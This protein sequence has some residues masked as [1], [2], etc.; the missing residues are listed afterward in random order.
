VEKETNGQTGPSGN[1]EGTNVSLED[2]SIQGAQ[3]AETTAPADALLIQRIRRGDT[4]AGH[5]FVREYYPGIYRYLLYLTGRAEAAED[6][7]QETFLRAWRRLDTF[8]EGAPFRPWL[9]RI[10][11]REFLQALRSQRLQFSLEEVGELPNPRA[12]EPEKAVELRVL[13]GALPVE[14]REMVVLHYLEGYEYAEIAHI[15]SIPVGRVRHRL[16]EARAR[17]AVELGEGDLIYLNEPAV[18]MRQWAWLPLDQIYALQARLSMGGPGGR[19]LG[20]GDRGAPEY[21]ASQEEAMER[22]EFL[23]HVAVGAAGLMLP[24][25]EKDVVDSRLMQKA[26]L[27]FKGTALSD[28]CEHLR[29]ETSVHVAAGASV[30]DEKVTLFCE[31][32]PLREVMRQLSRPFGYTWLRSGKTGEYRYELVQDLRSQLLEEEL[33]NR[34]RDAALLALDREMQRYRSYLSLTPEEA[35]IRSRTA[36]PQEKKLLDQLA[37][38]AWGAVQL[39]FR[40]SR[41]DLA[42]LRAGQPV[43]FSPT[44]GPGQRPIP[45]DVV[46]GVLQSWPGFRFLPSGKGFQMGTAEGLP[47]GVLLTAM[48]EARPVVALTLTQNELGQYTLGG[49]AGFTTDGNAGR[50]LAQWQAAADSFAGG[51]NFAI[52]DPGN[53]SFMTHLALATGTGPAN[54]NLKNEI[55]NARLSHD[56]AHRPRVSVAPQASCPPAPDLSPGPSIV[57]NSSPGSS[58]VINPSPGPSPKRGGE[59]LPLSDAERGPGGGVDKVTTA[60]VLEA[61]HRASGRPIVADY[62]TRLYPLGEVSAQN[63]PLFEALNRLADAMYVRWSKDGSWL[64]FRSATYYHDRLK[65]VPNRLLARWAESRRKHGALTLDDLVEIAQLSDAQLGAESMAEGARLCCGLTE[66][67]LAR[68][69]HL[70]SHLRYLAGLSPTQRNEALSDR[71]LAFTRLSLPQQQQFIAL[72]LGADAD[73]S[74]VGLDDLAPATL[75]VEYTVPGGRQWIAPQVPGGMARFAPQTSPRVSE[76]TRQAALEAMRRFDPHQEEAQLLARAFPELDLRFTYTLGASPERLMRRDANINGR[77]W[78]DPW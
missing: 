15:L 78:H 55:A 42:A 65:E 7:T 18:P 71:G 16:S 51:A 25:A 62:Y 21:G 26:T 28:V 11:H 73:P 37:G 46:R 53:G 70:R 41:N 12:A 40:L 67:D 43:T 56:P 48:P 72:A 34:E 10:A 58:R 69:R 66:W 31:K 3:S 4:D 59:P 27:A 23:R 45:P 50:L 60:D 2:G 33:R 49:A 54:L 20:A 24:E 52:G 32:L 8:R 57:T 74:K 35:L 63:V 75:R 68:A 44:P 39:Y 64:Q 47:K 22:R 76:K 1:A 19:A 6:L 17:L 9:H 38:Q 30:A 77:S 29:A 13:L 14:D 36:P 5:R 61:L